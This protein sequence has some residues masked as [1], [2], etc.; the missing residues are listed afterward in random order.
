MRRF[1]EDVTE[2]LEE[3][4][5]ICVAN[6]SV[7]SGNPLLNGRDLIPVLFGARQHE[8]TGCR[9]NQRH[10]IHFHDFAAH[11]ARKLV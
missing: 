11:A 3:Q 5:T 9:T 4:L 6:L 8:H 10:P 2:G 1:A 7:C